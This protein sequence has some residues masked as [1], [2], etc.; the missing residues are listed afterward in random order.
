MVLNQVN[1]RTRISVFKSLL[2]L[3]VPNSST[4]NAAYPTYLISNPQLATKTVQIRHELPE[5]FQRSYREGQ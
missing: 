5:K 1:T 4:E 3:Y 2:G